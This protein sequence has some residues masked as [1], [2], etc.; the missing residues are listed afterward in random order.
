[1]SPKA[2]ILQ[3]LSA[4]ISFAKISRKPSL[5]PSFSRR[6][7]G[8]SE[9][10]SFRRGLHLKPPSRSPLN[11]AKRFHPSSVR[12]SFPR[13][14]ACSSS[15]LPSSDSPQT[16]NN[17]CSKTS[18]VTAETDCVRESQPSRAAMPSLCGTPNC[19]SSLQNLCSFSTSEN[20][21]R[22]IGAP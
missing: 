14:P 12:S 8:E 3:S 21:K 22:T 19:F 10:L 2:N 5:F 16:I 7:R 15:A 17:H 18:N 20:A 11:F 6:K 13:L 9:G 1:M 4:L